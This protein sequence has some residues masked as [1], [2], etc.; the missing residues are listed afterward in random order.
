[1]EEL[2]ERWN[3][4]RRGWRISS[5]C[6]GGGLGEKRWVSDVHVQA[7]QVTNR[8]TR[9][10][11]RFTLRPRDKSFLTKSCCD[12]GSRTDV[13]GPCCFSPATNRPAW[14]ERKERKKQKCPRKSTL[15]KERC[16]C[17]LPLTPRLLTVLLFVHLG[18]RNQSIQRNVSKFLKNCKIGT[19]V[20]IGNVA[21]GKESC[22]VAFSFYRCWNE[23]GSYKFGMQNLNNC[24][25]ANIVLKKKSCLMKKD[26]IEV[27]FE[28][29]IS[30]ESSLENWN[31]W[32]QKRQLSRPFIDLEIKKDRARWI[33]PTKIIRVF[34]CKIGTIVLIGNIAL[35][36]E[37]CLVKKDLIEIFEFLILL[38]NL[39]EN[40]NN[41]LM[42]SSQK[43]EL[44]R[45]FIDLI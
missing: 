45:P 37:N 16:R 11:A 39:L 28:F 26:L 24:V 30:L 36:K 27:N 1:M 34:Q 3:G 14:N 7:G 13:S 9:A 22:L 10:T 21:L 15:P 4:P 20:L 12:S 6:G 18:T 29:L 5:G 44:P 32:F 19:I 35:G 38:E 25:I 17:W 31:D 8:C 40:W 2:V 43:R 23:K 33:Y 42:A 41:C